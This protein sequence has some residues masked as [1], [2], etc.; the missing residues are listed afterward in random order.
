MAKYQ[1]GIY[2]VKNREKYAGT[3][4]PTYRSSWERK[5][6]EM[7]D[8]NPH[9]LAW[10]SENIRIPYQHPFT[11]KITNYVP[12][13]MIKYVNKKGEQKVELIEIKPKSQMTLEAAGNSRVNVQAVHINAAKWEAA[14]RWCMSKGINFKV[15]SE[16]DIFF[17]QPKRIPK[18]KI[19]KKRKR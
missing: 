14:M 9:I 4:P 18:P 1:Q 12:D 10:D 2:T 13:F 7:C 19:P 3:K 16:E 15:I 11:G 5:F 6:C 17:K 8:N